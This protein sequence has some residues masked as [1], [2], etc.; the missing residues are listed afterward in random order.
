MIEPILW[1]LIISALGFLT[2]PLAYRFLPALAD[3]GYAFSRILGL[4]LWG[5]LFWLLGSL[6]ALKN[7]LGGELFALALVMLLS[8]WVLMSKLPSRF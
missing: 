6:G 2:F 4:L 3:R 5:Y 1:Y 7:D 8:A